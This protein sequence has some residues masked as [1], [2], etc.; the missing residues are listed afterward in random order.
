MTRKRIRLLQLVHAYP[1]AVGGVELSTRDLCEA[2]VA[3]YDFDVTVFTTNAFT[4]ANFVDGSLPTIP[5]DPGEEQNGVRIRRFPVVTHWAPVLR[6]LQRF[7]W[8]LK[9]PGNDRLRTWYHGPI[10]PEMLRR[11]G[12]STPTSSAPR[13]SRSTT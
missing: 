3:N 5:I 10:A 13:R 1:P 8:H 9:L 2:L 6:Q 11:C 7:A 12:S 4:V